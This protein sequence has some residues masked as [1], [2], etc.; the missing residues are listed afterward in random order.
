MGSRGD[1]KMHEL[2]KAVQLVDYVSSDGF[3]EKNGLLHFADHILD[4]LQAAWA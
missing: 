2:G 1:A 4:S 3:R